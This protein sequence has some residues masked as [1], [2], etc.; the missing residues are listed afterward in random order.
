M[1]GWVYRMLQLSAVAACSVATFVA[2]VTTSGA[3]EPTREHG[4]GSVR[5]LQMNLCD[6]GHAH[7]YTGRSVA[8]A[9]GVIQAEVPDVVTVNEVCQDDV[10]A[11][12]AVLA[13]TDGGGVVVS[14]FQAA[15]D[16]RTGAAIRCRNGRPYG[17]ALVARLAATPQGYDAVGGAYPMQDAGS[18]ELR[19]WLCLGARAAGPRP[20]GPLD[21]GPNDPGPINTGPAAVAVCTTHLSSGSPAVARA[22]CA[23]L[24][25][26]AI[27]AVRARAGSAPVILGG[28]LNLRSDD[29]PAAVACLPADDR[30]ADDGHVQHIVATPE[31]VVGTPRT[32]AMPA[33]DHPGLLVTLSRSRA[34]EMRPQ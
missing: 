6:S 14:A 28:D 15:W 13:G 22:Q 3:G 34:D 17:I 11:L 7:C 1:A 24:L 31:L 27:P 23:Y 29:S 4:A 5:V 19:A 18:P 8:E 33:T 9:G 16:R 10:A 2:V 25:G 26:T 21:A 12:E 32:I 30:R 20:P